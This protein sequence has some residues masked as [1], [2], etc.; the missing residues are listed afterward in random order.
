MKKHSVYLDRVIYKSIIRSFYLEN[1]FFFGFITLIFFLINSAGNV[2]FSAY[3]YI[4][5]HKHFFFKIFFYA[6]SIF[7]IIKSLLFLNNYYHRPVASFYFNSFCNNYNK[8]NI[9]LVGLII[10]FPI[11]LL[12]FFVFIS[13]LKIYPIYSLLNLLLLFV[14]IILCYISQYLILIKKIDLKRIYFIGKKK[15]FFPLQIYHE[16]YY[17]LFRRYIFIKILGVLV[18]LFSF[19]Y[20]LR[21]ENDFRLFGIIFTLYALRNLILFYNIK[22]IE[23]THFSFRKNLPVTI[24]NKVISNMLMSLLLIFPEIIAIS[25]FMILFNEKKII[26]L[27]LF[28]MIFLIFSNIQ[29]ILFQWK[30][31]TL[32]RHSVISIIFT[33]ILLI[34]IITGSSILLLLIIS[35]IAQIIIYKITESALH[36]PICFN[37]L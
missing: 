3:F 10:L 25:F 29:F 1:L 24:I 35:V 33:A 26:P 21:I 30:N 6:F 22:K 11:L 7:Y 9:F 31:L 8:L 15:Y 16:M 32:K 17:K 23:I 4:T 2:T 18:I 5:L 27:F 36:I 28:I 14:Y 13:I 37:E 12:H 20:V 34:Y 19:K